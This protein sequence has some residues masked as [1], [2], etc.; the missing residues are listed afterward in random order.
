ML[1]CSLAQLTLMVF[2]LAPCAVP[3]MAAPPRARLGGPDSCPLQL[4]GACS[5]SPT[6]TQLGRGGGGAETPRRTLL[7]PPAAAHL[8]H[9][10][11]LGRPQLQTYCRICKENISKYLDIIVVLFSLTVV[12]SRLWKCYLYI[13]L[14]NQNA[15]KMNNE[16][17]VAGRWW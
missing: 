2:S 14:H 8:Y 17:N 15:L 16:L 5:A 11:L 7:F 9:R 10:S 4:G 12:V 13:C 6:V 3:N 1:A